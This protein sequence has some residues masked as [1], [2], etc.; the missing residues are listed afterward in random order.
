MITAEL[1]EQELICMSYEQ[2]QQSA[3]GSPRIRPQDPL[4]TKF[5]WPQSPSVS[6]DLIPPRYKRR[7]EK[8]TQQSKW[9]HL[10]WVGEEQDLQSLLTN[11]LHFDKGKGLPLLG[12]G[13]QECLLHATGNKRSPSVN[14]YP[15]LAFTMIISTEKKKLKN[16]K[17]F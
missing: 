4:C 13:T 7:E 14:S 9:F 12:V 17:N 15:L 6:Q 10:V 8:Q 16:K 3:T 5:S 1:N 11:L 2:Y